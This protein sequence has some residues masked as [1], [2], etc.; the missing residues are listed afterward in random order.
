M[1]K[2][3]GQVIHVVIK[4]APAKIQVF[5]FHPCTLS[6][7]SWSLRVTLASNELRKHIP[8]QTKSSQYITKALLVHAAS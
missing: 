2:K 1:V 7:L 3:Y 8:L 5:C 4:L 6:G